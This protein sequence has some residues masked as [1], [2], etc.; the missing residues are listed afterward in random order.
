MTRSHFRQ[1]LLRSALHQPVISA[2]LLLFALATPS[3][4]APITWGTP[5]T[6]AGESDV[7]TT[8]SLVSAYSFFNGASTV[9]GVNFTN[10]SGTALGTYFQISTAGSTYSS[11][12]AGAAGTTYANLTSPYK[13]LLTNGRYGV[14]NSTVTLKSLTLGHQYAVQ[15]WSNDSRAPS[16]SPPAGAYVTLSGANSVNLPINSTGAAG[17]V[18]THSTG[19]FVADASTQT[20]TVGSSWGD[21]YVNAIQLR[22]LG[23]ATF[24][25][26]GYWNGTGGATWDATT[27][28]SWSLNDS[29]APLSS[30][31]FGAAMSASSGIAT[32]SDIYYDNGT[33]LPV[34]QNVVTIA[35]GG[36][37]CT[38]ASFP[39]STVA[40]TLNSADAT[41]LTGATALT[42]SGSSMLT[43]AGANTHTGATTIGAGSIRLGNALSLGS[44]PVTV[45]VAN[46]LSF[47]SGVGTFTLGNLAGNGGLALTDTGAAAITLK[48]GNGSDT[49]YSGTLSGAGGSLVKQG[50]GTLTL[51]GGSSLTGSVSVNAGNLSTQG[52]AADG[53]FPN[54]S[55]VTIN[56]GGTLTTG[57]NGLFG[58]NNHPVPVTVNA[59]GTLTVN[60]GANGGPNMFGTL[61]LAGGT[62][63]ED[64]SVHP[65]YGSYNFG[66]A[67]IIVTGATTSTLS[68]RDFQFRNA[69]HTV[70]VDAG[71]TL[72]VTGY[73]TGL[74][75]AAG[76][77]L[78]KTGTGKLI[79]A[80]AT[81]SS[82]GATNV[83][84]GTLELTGV[85]GTGK[86]TV[87]AG[88]SLAGTGT[89]GGVVEVLANGV[90]TMA[91]NAIAD[92]TLNSS[93][94]L[95]G[96]T[97]LEITKDGGTPATDQIFVMSGVTYGGTLTVTNITADA[98]T[99]SVG[100]SFKLFDAASYGGGF[101]TFN[102]PALPAGLSWDKSGLTATGTI[103]VINNVSS[104]VFTPAGGGYAGAQNVTISSDSG[105]TIYY[106][107]DG[108]TP[109]PSSPNG[110][111]PVSGIIVPTN[112]SKTIKA[113][114]VK[115]GQGNS[116]IATAQYTTVTTPTWTETFGG[117]WS[118]S[119]TAN[120]LSGVVANGSGVTADFSTLTLDADTPVTLTDAR[121]I[122][123]LHFGDVG[124]TYEWTLGGSELALAG[125]SPSITVDNQRT[126]IS[127]PL[128]GTAGMRK[129]G[130]GTLR[131]STNEDYTGN[132]L[133]NG[134]T[135][136][137]AAGGGAYT[138]S[139]LQGTL[140]VNSG[141]TCSLTSGTALGWG[142]GVTDIYLNG[143]D[144]SG[145]GAQ[146]F[147]VSYHLT[148]GTIN[149]TGSLRMG[150]LTG[151]PD[152]TLS[153]AASAS[154]SVI[155]ADGLSLATTFGQNSL[156]VTVAQ[157]T[158][159]SGVDLQI[160][161]P[162]SGGYTLVKA[163]AGNLQLAGANTYSGTTTV[164]EG[165]LTITGS[166]SSGT[167]VTGTARLAG[168]GNA[169]G[170]ATIGATAFVAP[171]GSGAGELLSG[172]TT[173]DGTY[174]CQLDGAT[175][176]RLTV[177][178]NLTFGA[179]STIACST[180][181]GGAT[182]ST[183]VI[184]SYTGTLAG[185]P[186]VTG[187]PVGYSL[188]LATPNQVRLVKASG[189]SDWATQWAGGQGINQDFD[190]DGVANGIEFFMGQTTSGFT[191]GPSLSGKTISWT[192]GASYPGTYGV[193]Y[194]IETS[195]T[196]G[197]GSWTTVPA[198]DP[199]LNNGS[200]LQYTLPTG[201]PKVFS[202]LVVTGP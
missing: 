66:G 10:G 155:N 21:C 115:A 194:R 75:H 138:N 147:G 57:S 64:N 52:P 195:A 125:A 68:A 160:N 119:E 152:V 104:P 179:T 62:V 163:G 201:Q 118:D 38:T 133:V 123:H 202:R 36:A 129:E 50:G 83:N 63:A 150:V 35:A 145:S 108:S 73:F 144:L 116:A 96:T 131:L 167:T 13:T 174:Q 51:T 182:E 58:Y 154:T 110:P 168:T 89:A 14:K 55:S 122:G 26:A 112:S 54:A 183:Y 164:N 180:L 173:V 70:Q 148:G 98:S 69:A 103:T 100:D 32:F 146:A 175:S 22:D 24:S 141:A 114:A 107:L 20:F 153:S 136:E 159:A 28:A 15:V 105:S 111:S 166:V 92:L 94:T 82:H 142:G 16:G 193:D 188:D 162:I 197:A 170:G 80:S 59:G 127:A 53:V 7:S 177:S 40:Y 86:I 106:T 77:T 97:A 161:A 192:K 42:K 191:A 47:A 1:D 184:A 56:N 34:T 39:S 135:L 49:S 46:G 4:A 17:A 27:T 30:G 78:N 65:T 101:T 8:G 126:I 102:L 181:P 91:D 5:A 12:G 76:K 81:A 60:G 93:V 171:A 158:T 198:N 178:G 25:T 48:V 132:T 37:S 95:A 151:F 130:A 109:G 41:G 2:G 120:W 67:S 84:E 88:A 165:T 87:A 90:L 71:S 121:T 143:G 31:T 200:P 29:T 149:A 187:M 43:L 45:S 172:A 199:N 128:A 189:Y 44:S 196:L 157:G 113:Y 99:L 186:Q 185:T 79:L 23:T 6:I 139:T 33:T 72:N 117:N 134:G 140:T 61:T 85:H 3:I 74:A 156:A 137:L 124:N 169:A 19:T 176:D 9:N 190:G 18:G 11:F